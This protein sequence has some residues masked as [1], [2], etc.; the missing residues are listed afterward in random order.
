MRFETLGYFLREALTGIRRNGFMSFASASTVFVSLVVLSLLL[1][2][3]AN[4]RYL[5]SYVES[6]VAVVAFLSPDMPREE[7]RALER[8]IAAME[9][10]AETRF[11]TREQALA[12]LKAM[13][14]DRADLLEG[15]EQ[16]NPLRDSIEV[17]LADPRYGDQV[18]AALRQAQGVQ[19]VKYRR[20]LADRIRRMGDAVRAGS[21]LLVGLLAVTTLFLISNT[22]RLTVYARR[23]EI[24][25]MKLVGATD[26]FIRWPLVIEGVLLG[27]VGAGAA[28]ALAWWGYDR[29]V[30]E[31][32]R[33][34]P[35]VPLVP[36]EPLLNQVAQV[37][38]AGGALLGALGSAMSLRRH[39]RV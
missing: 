15:V 17:R 34:V 7:G 25:I 10:V 16:E 35:F 9:G 11:V 1:V 26:W 27:L 2:V 24:Q 14:G 32:T 29:L 30:V 33:A 31:V 36:K 4:V 37:L 38:V 18:S 23:R 8:R 22:I 13:F 6:Q 12:D 5:A 19:D 28:A 3:A 39:L 20:D 21:A